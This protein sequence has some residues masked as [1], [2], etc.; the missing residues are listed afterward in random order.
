MTCKKINDLNIY[1]VLRGNDYKFILIDVNSLTIIPYLN[2]TK[3]LSNDNINITPFIETF[4]LYIR[5]KKVFKNSHFIF[6]FDGGI[7]ENILKVY[8]DYKKNR[9]TRKYLNSR[10]NGIYD[11]NIKLCNLIFSMFNELVIDDIQRNETDFIIGRLLTKLSSEK[12]LVLSHDQDYLLM[13]D[14]NTDI[15][16]KEIK[17]PRVTYYYI[18]NIDCICQLIKFEYLKN[19][20]ELMYYKA[21]VGDKSDNITKP[22]G[23]KSKTIVNNMFYTFYMEEINVTYDRIIEYFAKKIKN[24][25]AFE[26]FKKT[27]RRNLYIINIFNNDIISDRDKLKINNHLNDFIYNNDDLVEINSIYE[28]FDKYGLFFTREDIDKIFKYLKV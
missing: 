11:Y 15:I 3:Y 23:I 1:N 17:Q 27:F 5:Y 8:P 4:K 18:N 19:I 10:N 12:K 13:L 9:R 25:T 14:D 28:V 21:M 20:S 7:S 26:K 6:V 24:E 2:S 22:F 16:Y